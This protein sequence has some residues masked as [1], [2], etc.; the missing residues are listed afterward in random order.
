MDFITEFSKSKDYNAILMI[1][2]KLI[3]MRHYITYRAEEKEI[4]VKQ[5]A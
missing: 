4:S 2:D 3:K 1:I 5:T